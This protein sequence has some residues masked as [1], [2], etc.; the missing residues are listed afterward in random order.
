MLWN[1]K[2]ANLPVC[3]T[4]LAYHQNA[5]PTRWVVERNRS[6]GLEVGSPV[7]SNADGLFEL[8]RVCDAV[9]EL[10]NEDGRFQ[11]NYRTCFHLTL[12]TRLNSDS[13]L[14]GFLKGLQRLEPGLMTLV[15]PSRLFGFD[16]SRYDIGRRNSYC[17][18]TRDGVGATIHGGNTLAGG[19]VARVATSLTTKADELQH[20]TGVQ[21]GLVSD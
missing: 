5:D 17:R 9:T 16:G 1:C 21:I 7:L 20:F 4:P 6:A 11:V 18:P 12:G 2:V 3:Q 19:V 10:I 13:S 8:R 15:S 14:R